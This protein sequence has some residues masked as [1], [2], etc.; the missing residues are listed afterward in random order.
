V[1][2]EFTRREPVAA[3]KSIQILGRPNQANW[4]GTKKAAA[5]NVGE[6]V[7][8]TGDTVYQFV[9]DEQEGLPKGTKIVKRDTA[10]EF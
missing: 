7:S 1:C 5:I 4:A 3:T 6:K 9:V 10:L 2:A 8:A